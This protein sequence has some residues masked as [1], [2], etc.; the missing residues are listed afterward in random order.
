MAPLE[1]LPFDQRAADAYGGLR[2]GLERSGG[3]IGALDTLIAAQ[4]LAEKLTLVTNNQ[5]HF[6]RVANLHVENWG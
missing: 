2:T 5:R 3:P 4:A 6:S 1:V